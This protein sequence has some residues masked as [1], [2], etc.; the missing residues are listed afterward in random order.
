MP[1]EE[2]APCPPKG[3]WNRTCAS[4]LERAMG[5]LLF[6]FEVA[7]ATLIG[8][9]FLANRL[10]G[11]ANALLTAWVACAA[12]ACVLHPEWRACLPGMDRRQRD[13]PVI[14]DRRRPPR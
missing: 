8:L 7:A 12:V 3:G 10:A 1:K 2:R 5:T 6:A 4:R 11:F 9:T 14:R 13:V